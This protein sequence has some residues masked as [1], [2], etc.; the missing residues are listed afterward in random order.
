MG[1]LYNLSV[2]YTR[3]YRNNLLYFL[4]FLFFPLFSRSTLLRPFSSSDRQVF[5]SEENGVKGQ[6]N[7]RIFIKTLKRCTV[8]PGIVFVLSVGPEFDD[9]RSLF[10][11]DVLYLYRLAKRHLLGISLPLCPATCPVGPFRLSYE[12]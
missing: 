2:D 4:L 6:V 9:T 12:L 8:R 10:A 3:K 1:P 11:V 7:T 5:L